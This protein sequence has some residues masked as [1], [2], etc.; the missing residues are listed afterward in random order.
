M[1]DKKLGFRGTVI[2][3]GAALVIFSASLAAAFTISWFLDRAVQS[4]EMSPS[5]VSTLVQELGD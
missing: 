4:V 2:A 1:A 5:D 3:I